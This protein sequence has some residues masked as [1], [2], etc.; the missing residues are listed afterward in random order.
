MDLP[1]VVMKRRNPIYCYLC[2]NKS[3]IPRNLCNLYLM[4][5][6]NF[7]A[8][9][10]RK[11]LSDAILALETENPKKIGWIVLLS[12]KD[13][14]GEAMKKQQQITRQ[15]YEKS[16]Y[17][18]SRVDKI[19]KAVLLDRRPNCQTPEVRLPHMVSYILEEIPFAFTGIEH[20]GMIY[21]REVKPKPL[22]IFYLF[23]GQAFRCTSFSYVQPIT[24]HSL[25]M[26]T[27]MLN[28]DW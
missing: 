12:W 8:A 22:D 24:I 28:C 16:N 3:A 15:H 21:I 17:F 26:L 2:L 4:K 23:G 18:K 20:Q 25:A 27:A 5:L 6:S 9:P 14:E 13:I 10:F 1:L 7:T 11:S 19:A